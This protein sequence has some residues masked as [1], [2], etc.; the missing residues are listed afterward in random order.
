MHCH[1]IPY[2]TIAN[3]QLYICN[4]LY[5]APLYCFGF[6]YLFSATFFSP[7]FFSCTLF[8]SF[9]YILACT[10]FLFSTFFLLLCIPLFQSLFTLCLTL[11]RVFEIHRFPPYVYFLCGFQN[12]T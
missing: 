10:F 12:A 1:T 7:H 5:I 3:Q 8:F 9:Y 4:S 2:H 11:V 6:V